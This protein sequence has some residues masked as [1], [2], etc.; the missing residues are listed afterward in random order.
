M[1]ET[2]SLK[3]ELLI[4]NDCP[5]EGQ[6]VSPFRS[7]HTAAGAHSRAAEVVR[8]GTQHQAVDR[9]FH[10]SPSFFLDGQD[11]L[12]ADTTPPSVTCRLY[13]TGDGAATTSGP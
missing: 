10:G 9:E 2:D 1:T 4:V 8:I 6:A 11:L 7:A 13:R 12:A 5:I 3:W